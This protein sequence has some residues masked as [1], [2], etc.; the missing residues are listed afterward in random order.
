MTR[1]RKF[2]PCVAVLLF[3]AE[4]LLA[5]DAPDPAPPPPPPKTIEYVEYR[6]I[7]FR[8]PDGLFEGSMGFNL[9]FRFTHFDLD[10]AAGGVDANE[11][12]VR[13]FKLFFSGFALDP[14]LTWRLQLAFEST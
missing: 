11:F 1:N 4:R 6:G 13:R 5:D 7:V 10:A 12:R 8:T 2:L 3:A 9:Q 14:R